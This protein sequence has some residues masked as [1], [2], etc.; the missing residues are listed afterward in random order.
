MQVI[1][2][3]N[4]VLDEPLYIAYDKEDQEIAKIITS[5]YQSEHKINSVKYYKQQIATIDNYCQDL[6]NSQKSKTE[7]NSK[8][9]K[10]KLIRM[11]VEARL[12]MRRV[13][14]STK[15]YFIPNLAKLLTT[16]K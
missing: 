2:I 1:K 7:I 14:H 4:K 10:L 6:R 12:L 8:L 13:S 5:L 11:M 15:L 16:K 9:S 3:E